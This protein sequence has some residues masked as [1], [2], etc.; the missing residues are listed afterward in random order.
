MKLT[1][2]QKQSLGI[3]FD[4]D[5]VPETEIFKAAESLA[6]KLAGVDTVNIA[7]L[8]A[9]AAAGDKYTELQRTEVTRLAKLAELGADDG[10][11]EAVVSQTIADADFDRLVQL[12]SYYQKKVAERFPETARSSQEDSAAVEAAGGVKKPTTVPKVGLH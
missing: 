9:R 7:K 10:E 5:E 12:Q 4:G 1:K 2:E 6:E 11:L 3:E 8:T